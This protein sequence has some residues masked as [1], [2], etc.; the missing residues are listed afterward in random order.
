MLN[1]ENMKKYFAGLVSGLFI[2][3]FL[4]A[5]GIYYS[6]NER[7]KNYA[8]RIFKKP[9]HARS[10]SH[11]V[12]ESLKNLENPTEFEKAAAINDYLYQYLFLKNHIGHHAG[13]IL[14]QRQGICGAHAYCLAEMLRIAE[15][16]CKQAFI[17]GAPVMGT[18][19]MVQVFFS[20][21]EIGLFD[22]TFG[23]YWKSPKSGKLLS[24]EELI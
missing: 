8:F 10:L 20:N 3:I 1:L 15:V 13:E 7:I 18:H 21:G 12:Y 5:G 19:E 11:H 17:H 2:S 4:A 14:S 24:I 22:P 16:P 23:V 9:I 6:K